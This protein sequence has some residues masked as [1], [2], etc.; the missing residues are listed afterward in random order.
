MNIL[1]I[2]AEDAI[3]QE[4][5]DFLSGKKQCRIVDLPLVIDSSNVLTFPNLEIRINEQAVY[6]NGIPV[7]LTHYEF[8]T[9]LYLALHP[10]WVLSKE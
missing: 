9:L 7:P 4:V 1:M 5:V 8:F 6:H 3:L 10:F 2:E